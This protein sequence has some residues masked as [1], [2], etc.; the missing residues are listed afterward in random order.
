MFALG[1]VDKQKLV[2]Q[3]QQRKHQ[4]NSMG[5]PR[6]RVTIQFD[7]LWHGDSSAMCSRESAQRQFTS[8]VIA[9]VEPCCALAGLSRITTPSNP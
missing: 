5:V 4:L 3:L 6:K 2:G 8:V 9:L 7:G 1:Q